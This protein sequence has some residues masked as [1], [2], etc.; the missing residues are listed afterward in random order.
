MD[1]ELEEVAGVD[2]VEESL[3]WIWGQGGGLR[4]VDWGGKLADRELEW[5]WPGAEGALAP[6]AL[7]ANDDDE[8]AVAEEEEEEDDADDED[9]AAEVEE[10][11]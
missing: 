6:V 4:D 10:V 2:E 3:S 5:E 9:E 1:D 11:G 7:D 8:E